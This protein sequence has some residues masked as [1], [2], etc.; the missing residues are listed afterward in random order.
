MGIGTSSPNYNLEVNG[1]VKAN[2]LITE[3]ITGI[4]PQPTIAKGSA[5]N[6]SSTVTLEGTNLGGL[7]TLT[8]SGSAPTVSATLFTVTY[9]H[10]NAFPNDSYVIFYQANDNAAN[11]AGSQ[12]QNVYI[13]ASSTNFVVKSGPIGLSVVT[14]KWN[15]IVVGR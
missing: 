8:L 13:D 7:I 3:N 9:N 12:L 11:I 5:L 10:S 1:Q 2:N 6:N 4:S 14:Y 15:Y